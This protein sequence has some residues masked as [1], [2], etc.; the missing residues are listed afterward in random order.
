ML[1]N[2]FDKN[3]YI[4][5]TN[6]LYKNAKNALLDKKVIKKGN[7]ILIYEID[8]LIKKGKLI[9]IL[10]INKLPIKIKTKKYIKYSCVPTNVEILKDLKK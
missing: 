4:S 7:Q 8:S 5:N 1:E 2:L 9:K 3:R 6:L 10:E